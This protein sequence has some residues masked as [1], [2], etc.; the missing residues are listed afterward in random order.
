[1]GEQ[2]YLSSIPQS[3]HHNY[4]HGPDFFLRLMHDCWMTDKTQIHSP[5]IGVAIM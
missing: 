3:I 1:M 5:I 4:K 2:Q